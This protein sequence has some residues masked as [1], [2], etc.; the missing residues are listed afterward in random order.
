MPLGWNMVHFR[1][2][3]HRRHRL[4]R[5]MIAEMATGEGKTLVGTLPVFS[6][7]AHRTRRARHHGE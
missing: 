6:Q 5:G 7:R 3:A 2:A 4:H 1:R